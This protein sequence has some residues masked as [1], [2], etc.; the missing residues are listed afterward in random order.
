MNMNSIVIYRTF[1]FVIFVKTSD[2]YNKFKYNR[3][4]DEETKKPHEREA[5]LLSQSERGIRPE[6]KHYLFR[7]PSELLLSEC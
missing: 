7:T 6:E 3:L 1:K 4:L 5:V 2:N